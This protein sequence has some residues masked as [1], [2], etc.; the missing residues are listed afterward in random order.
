[1]QSEDSMTVLLGGLGAFLLIIQYA[2]LIN[3]KRYGSF[4]AFMYIIPIGF[5]VYWIF[6]S[7]G[8][9]FVNVAEILLEVIPDLFD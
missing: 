7:V 8:F 9:I 5:Y 1:V 6:R 4:K 3:L 2:A